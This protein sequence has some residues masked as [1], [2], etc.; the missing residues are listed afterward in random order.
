MSETR[1]PIN[2]EEFDAI[3]EEKG[4]ECQECGEQIRFADKDSY[5]AKK[6]CSRCFIDLEVE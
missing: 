5:E 4:W 3:A 2:A 6:V 1:D